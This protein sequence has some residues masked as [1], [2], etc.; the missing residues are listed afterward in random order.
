MWPWFAR[1][2]N[3]KGEAFFERVTKEAKDAS[4]P[5]TWRSGGGLCLGV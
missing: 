5:M 1:E 2:A 4:V 3:E